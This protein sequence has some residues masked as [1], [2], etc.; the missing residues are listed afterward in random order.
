M[1]QFMI[2]WGFHSKFL[3]LISSGEVSLK[4]D[5]MKTTVT[6][7]SLFCHDHKVDVLRLVFKNICTHLGML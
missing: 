7:P 5:V 2:D 1:L 3:L 6:K 4:L